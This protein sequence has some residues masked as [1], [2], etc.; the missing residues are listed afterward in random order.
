MSK[1]PGGEAGAP[2][3]N[4]F[5]TKAALLRTTGLS[6][7]ISLPLVDRQPPLGNLSFVDS[8]EGVLA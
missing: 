7:L 8:L 3:R 4:P 6:W 2:G 1:N 5:L